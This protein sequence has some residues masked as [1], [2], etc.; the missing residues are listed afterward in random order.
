MQYTY[1]RCA[2][3]LRGLTDFTPSADIDYSILTDE[4]SV[5]L[6]KELSRYPKV[7]QDA[8]ERYEPF[9]VA[10]FAISVSQVFNKFYDANRI[11]VE[12]VNVRNARAT[13]VY[14]VKTVIKDAMSLLGI[15]CPEQM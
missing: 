15:E 13:L 10:R 7:V 14:I 12:D 2:S 5:D 3:I 8:A 9:V 1:A 6:V 4:A 11:N